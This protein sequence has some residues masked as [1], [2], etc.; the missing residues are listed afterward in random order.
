MFDFS[1][2][3]LFLL[4]LIALLV[5]GP[6]KLPGAARTV[7]TLIRRLR[8]GWEDARAQVERELDIEEIRRATREAQEQARAA[9]KQ[10]DATLRQL[11]AEMDKTGADIENS[12]AKIDAPADTDAGPRR[13][14]AE[15]DND[16]PA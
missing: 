2:G 6:D 15:K 16:G 1:L 11:R 8:A 3:K 10:A 9:Q 13:I 12:A 5:L 7:G 14:A 4:A